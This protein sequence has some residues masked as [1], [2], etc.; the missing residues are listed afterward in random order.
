MQDDVDY[1]AKWLASRYNLAGPEEKTGLTDPL[2]IALEGASKSTRE[3]ICEM[4]GITYIYPGET[5]Q[6]DDNHTA[7]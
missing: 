7:V 5:E 2:V 1:V 4:L 3:A 6:P